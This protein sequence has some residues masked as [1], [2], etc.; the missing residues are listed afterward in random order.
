MQEL[1]KTEVEIATAQIIDRMTRASKAASEMLDR[2]T[3]GDSRNLLGVESECRA[4]YDIPESVNFYL[5]ECFLE[6]HM[7][8]QLKPYIKAW[9]EGSLA[10]DEMEY[11]WFYF[12]SLDEID[13][14]WVFFEKPGF[15]CK[16]NQRDLKAELAEWFGLGFRNKRKHRGKPFAE[17]IMPDWCK[18]GKQQPWST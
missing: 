7:I 17:A 10:E 8:P 9:V 18:N 13:V 11:M 5:D 16:D 3:V 1:T 12:D 15:K 6:P 14:L 2:C 4:K